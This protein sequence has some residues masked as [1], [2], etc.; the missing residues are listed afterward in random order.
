[1]PK[2]ADKSFTDLYLKN[3]K[4]LRQR[5]DYFDAAQR[6]LGIRVAPS[7][8]KTWFVMRRVHTR[9]TRKTLGRYP[10]LSLSEAR[11]QA[12]ELLSDMAKGHKPERKFAP[13]FSAVMLDWF[14]KDQKGKRGIAEKRRAL[15]VD[16]LPKLGPVPIDAIGKSDIR[17]IIDGIV[18]RGAP[19]HANRVLA[20]LR[21]LFN[22]AVER[23]IITMSP[24]EKIRAPAPE[25]S[26]DRTLT[27]AELAAVWTAA[28]TFAAPFRVY[29]QLLIL[30]G[31]R[32]NEVAGALWRE[33]DLERGEWTI[34]ASRAKNGSAHLVHLA[35]EAVAILAAT[36]RV[37][38]SDFVFT[39]T[40]TTP[41]SGF[42]KM[43]A[44]LDRQSGVTGW[45]IHDLRRTFATIGT[46]ELGIDPVV[47]DKILNHRSG[48]VTGVAAVYQRAAYLE[49]RRATLN[50]WC[51]YV[52]ELCLD[53]LPVAS[54]RQ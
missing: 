42:S 51:E 15:S 54:V 4:P 19:I 32:R 50:A 25:K 45:T 36:P 6:G 38:G 29:F 10:D 47:M 23:D 12:G 43:K 21:R 31:Q 30:T 53:K 14:D 34:P 33:F 28:S 9:M 40:G 52:T 46:G 5:R 3:L 2:L 27:G 37:H 35:P 22:W 11:L 8:L 24:A 48:V 16:V 7:G 41:I 13:V 39:T 49:Q 17:S 20:Y 44:I 18:A 1:M 26:R